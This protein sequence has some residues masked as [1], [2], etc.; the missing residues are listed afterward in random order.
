MIKFL[1]FIYHY[2]EY[3]IWI[4][5]YFLLISNGAL[6]S[7]P[8]IVQITDNMINRCVDSRYSSPMFG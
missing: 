3:T 7:Y 8:R 6:V 1:V 2:G 5:N 4:Y